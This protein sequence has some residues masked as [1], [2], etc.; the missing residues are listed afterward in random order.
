MPDRTSPGKQDSRLPVGCLCIS[1]GFLVFG[2]FFLWAF[3]SGAPSPR[4]GNRFM[5]LIFGSVWL[6]FG[7]IGLAGLLLPLLKRRR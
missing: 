7:L 5:L 3:F 2:A 4:T 1:L 6:L